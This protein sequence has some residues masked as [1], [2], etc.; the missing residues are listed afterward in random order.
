MA[1]IDTLAAYDK[2]IAAGLSEGKA[3]ALVHWGD[4][5]LNGLATKEDL[6]RLGKDITSIKDDIEK[7]RYEVKNNFFCMIVLLVVGLIITLT[8]TLA[9]FDVKVEQIGKELKVGKHAHN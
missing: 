7:S 3:R 1:N 4:A 2:L 5:S 6:N 8:S 9:A